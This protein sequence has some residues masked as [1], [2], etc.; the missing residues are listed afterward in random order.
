MSL[1][2]K[3][4][5]NYIIVINKYKKKKKDF[6]MIIPEKYYKKWSIDASQEFTPV[7]MI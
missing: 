4:R 1:G 2:L 7:M 6:M 3:Y 5:M